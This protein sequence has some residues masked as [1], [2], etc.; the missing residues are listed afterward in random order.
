MAFFSP[1]AVAGGSERVLDSLAGELAN[2]GAA[3]HVVVLGE[4]ALPEWLRERGLP[5]TVLPP[6]R[7]RDPRWLSRTV[8][9]VRRVVRRHASDV[10]VSNLGRGHLIGAAAVRGTGARRIWWSHNIPSGELF[11]WDRAAMLLGADLIVAVSDA[12]AAGHRQM[13]PRLPLVTIHNGVAIPDDAELERE[14]EQARQLRGELGW[15]DNP[16][17]AIVGRLQGWKGQETF[18]R[19]AALVLQRIPSARFLVVGGAI[20]GWE[21]DYEAQLKDLARELRLGD[22]VRFVGHQSD[23]GPWYSAADVVVNAS[24]GEP[25]GTVLLEAMARCKPLVVTDSGGTPE[26]VTHEQEGLL[27]PARNPEAMAGALCRLVND[28]PLALALGSHGRSRVATD[29]SESA[30]GAR[31]AR[32]LG[33]W[34]SVPRVPSTDRRAGELG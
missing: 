13:R 12:V 9:A 34:L 8:H 20:L 10:L 31:W 21:G 2:R 22:S 14:V 3:V 1:S 25:F 32:A 6:G 15:A 11:G 17:I 19:A 30:M 33:P 5:L 28:R 4:G 18:L 24:V 23:V 27:V 29:F 26:I 16:V 7:V